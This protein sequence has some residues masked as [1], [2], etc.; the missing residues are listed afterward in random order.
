MVAQLLEMRAVACT[1]YQILGWDFPPRPIKSA[2]KSLWY[3][4]LVADWSGKDEA[5]TCPIVTA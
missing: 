4:D 1:T 2:T 5:L 3:G